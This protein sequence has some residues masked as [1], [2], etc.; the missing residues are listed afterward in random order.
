MTLFKMACRVKNR[1]LN[2]VL[3][4]LWMATK[5]V[6]AWSGQEIKVVVGW[7]AKGSLCHLM[8][9]DLK[10]SKLYDSSETDSTT[11]WDPREQIDIKAS[12]WEV[13]LPPS[14]LRGNDKPP[15]W[16]LDCLFLLFMAQ[17][18]FK[19]RRYVELEYQEPNWLGIQGGNSAHD[20]GVGPS[21]IEMFR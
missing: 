12:V 11:S 16:L 21:I 3:T 6:L 9:I 1:G 8:A 14:K 13:I 7:H 10:F 18:F 5:T 2:H 20:Q 15:R 17:W 19:A 4:H